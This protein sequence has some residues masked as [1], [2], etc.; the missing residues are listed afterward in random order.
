M[1]RQGDV[2]VV[3][4]GLLKCGPSEQQPADDLV[5]LAD[6]EHLLS[7]RLPNTIASC[8]FESLLQS[9]RPDLPVVHGLVDVSLARAYWE[10]LAV[11]GVEAAPL[12]LL[13]H[14]VTPEF[15]RTFSHF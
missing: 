6:A 10:A 11:A 15:L 2:L 14:V 13:Q 12:H 1:E 4:G 8:Q 3:G 9:D 7:L 5:M